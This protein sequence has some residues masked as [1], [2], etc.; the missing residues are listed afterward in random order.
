M[1]DIALQKTPL[2]TDLGVIG[3]MNAIEKTVYNDYGV[4]D[5]YETPNPTAFRVPQ[6]YRAT[7]PCYCRA[8]DETWTHADYTAL[9]KNY[10]DLGAKVPKYI[11][12]DAEKR[13]TKL[14]T[15]M[16]N[17]N[18]YAMWAS[19][20]SL[21]TAVIEYSAKEKPLKPKSVIRRCK[22]YNEGLE[23]IKSDPSLNLSTEAVAALDQAI[24]TTTSTKT[25][26]ETYISSGEFQKH[27]DKIAAEKAKSVFMPKAATQNSGLEAGAK[28]YIKGQEYADYLDRLD[29][30]AVAS[31]IRAVS[32]NKG[33]FVHKNDYDIPE[34]QYKEI[35][36]AYKDS[37]GI[38][39]KA[40]VYANYTYKGGGTYSTVANWGADSPTQIACE[41]VSISK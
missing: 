15:C 18:K 25:E 40:T 35:V 39:H 17:G 28:K 29:K 38:C 13:W 6:G 9:K 36:V 11:N 21:K 10:R 19:N 31:T 20:E 41:N 14:E 8:W 24:E 33:Y 23:R 12:D 2:S 32:V 37:K 34:Y 26:A 4:S 30:N 7:A 1:N 27:L 5:K 3:E 22:E 16:A